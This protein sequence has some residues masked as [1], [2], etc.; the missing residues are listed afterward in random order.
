MFKAIRFL[1]LFPILLHAQMQQGVDYQELTAEISFNPIEKLVRG[2]VE[3]SF[4]LKQK[5]D[6]IYLDAIAM[7]FDSVQINGQPAQWKNTQKRIVF[8]VNDLSST[9]TMSF[10]YKAH[11][12]KHF[13]LLVGMMI[14]MEMNRYGPKGKGNIPAIGCPV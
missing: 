4:D 9:N 11:P 10:N 7:E 12:K 13:T 3:I 8:D 14:F 6:S 5:V 1:C 2:H